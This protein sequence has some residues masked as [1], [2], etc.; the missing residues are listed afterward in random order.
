MSQTHFKSD[1]CFL[2]QTNK[3][4]KSI[5]DYTINPNPFI[6]KNECVDY[7]Q[8]SFINYIPKGIPQINIDIENELRGSTRVNTKCQECKYNP[9]DIQIQVPSNKKECTSAF[10]I[11][12]NGYYQN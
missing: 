12:P 8:T 10:K 9:E 1:N 5:I 4:N 2:N 7:T 11:L 3:S 6:N